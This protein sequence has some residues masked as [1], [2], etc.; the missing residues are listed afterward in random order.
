MAA[1]PHK[2]YPGARIRHIARGPPTDPCGCAKRQAEGVAERP[3]MCTNK[4]NLIK[5]K[6]PFVHRAARPRCPRWVTITISLCMPSAYP[7]R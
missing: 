7:D 2:A 4:K 3:R 5:Q 1:M 6:I